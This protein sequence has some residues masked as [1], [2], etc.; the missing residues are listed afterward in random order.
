M[1]LWHKNMIPYL[2][3]QQLLGQWRELC[4]IAANLANEHTPNHLLV[5]PIL[6]YPP[7]HFEYYCSLVVREMRKRDISI[8]DTVM[9]TLQNNIR[10]WRIY[11][12]QE[13]PFNFVD[14]DIEMQFDHDKL[15]KDW[16]N[17]RYLE[18]CYCNLE[19]KYDRGGIPQ[20]EWERF[21]CWYY[22][23]G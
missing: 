13:V 23:K 7:E 1:R 2:P 18:Q 6:D 21:C 5:N 16:H 20:K 9:K 22:R 4:C 11:L 17:E 15:F 3:Q 8:T 19:E 10:A 12:D 14:L